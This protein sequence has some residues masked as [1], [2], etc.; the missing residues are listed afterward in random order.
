MIRVRHKSGHRATDA[1]INAMVDLARATKMDEVWFGEIIEAKDKNGEIV[2]VVKDQERGTYLTLKYA[3]KMLDEGV[4]HIRDYLNLEEAVEF[5]S[6][7]R[8]VGLITKTMEKRWFWTGRFVSKSRFVLSSLV[9]AILDHDLMLAIYRPMKICKSKK[10]GLYY[11]D[12]GDTWDWIHSTARWF[13][14]RSDKKDKISYDIWGHRGLS[15]VN[16]FYHHLKIMGVNMFT[17]TRAEMPSGPQS[18]EDIVAGK[19]EEEVNEGQGN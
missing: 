2:H 11:L 5:E 12:I 17:G 14:G 4:S 18:P 13:C 6:L 3:V 15:G 19:F 8:K 9:K 16:R 1:Q 7:M 10:S